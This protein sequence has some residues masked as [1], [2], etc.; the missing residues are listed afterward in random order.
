MAGETSPCYKVK[1]RMAGRTMEGYLSAASIDGLETFDKGLKNAAVANGIGASNANTASPPAPA[2]KAKAF[3]RGV[4]QVVVAQAQEWIEQNQPAKA[5]ELLETEVRKFK[6]PNLLAL[7]GYAAWRADDTRRALELW[8][9]SLKLAPNP[10][11]EDLFKRVERERANDQ[12]GERLYGVRVVLR[13]EASVV[14]SD[15]ARQM[16]S[17]V[18]ATYARVSSQLGCTTNERIPTI[19][20]SRDAYLKTTNAAEWSGGLY[21]GRIHIPAMTGQAMTADAERVLAHETTHACLSLLGHWPSWLQEGMA[22]KLS[23]ETMHPQ[24]RARLAALAKE[25][26]LPKLENLEGDWSHLDSEHAYLAY[27]LALAAVEK[28]YET[29]DTNGVRNLLRNPEQLS[30]VSANLDKQIGL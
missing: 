21:D 13:Y 16:L 19:V 18:D 11:I 10:Q 4:S 2:F 6:D 27:G 14:P 30:T 20:Q 7:A 28:L 17:V 8:D 5:L 9:E 24:T 1:A 25:G 23:G 15:T 26:K 29:L 12:S 22:Q 3:G